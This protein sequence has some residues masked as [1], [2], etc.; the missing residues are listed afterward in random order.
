MQYKKSAASMGQHSKHASLK[1]VLLANSNA[2]TVHFIYV[3]AVV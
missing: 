1:Y 2:V 3:V